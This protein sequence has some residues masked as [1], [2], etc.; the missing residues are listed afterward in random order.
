MTTTSTPTPTTWE[1]AA[2]AALADLKDSHTWVI[3]VLNGD[4]FTSRL[5]HIADI[6]YDLAVGGRYARGLYSAFDNVAEV[7]TYLGVDQGDDL[8]AL[9]VEKQK[10][11]GPKN[12]TKFGVKGIGIRLSDKAQRLLNL[13]SKGQDGNHDESVKDTVT[14][15]LGYCVVGVMN[16]MGWMELPIEAPKPKRVYMPR[17]YITYPIAADYATRNPDSVVLVEVVA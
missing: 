12:I 6:A 8:I 16:E 9:L 2:R 15:M 13:R 10:G 3:P 5:N 14:D 1:D 11:Y 7:A 17:S 4:E